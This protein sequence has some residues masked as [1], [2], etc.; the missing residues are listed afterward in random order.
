MILIGLNLRLGDKLNCLLIIVTGLF[1]KGFRIVSLGKKNFIPPSG[2]PIKRIETT[3]FFWVTH[4]DVGRLSRFAVALST[5]SCHFFVIRDSISFWRAYKLMYRQLVQK[6]KECYLH[7]KIN[8]LLKNNE[9]WTG[10]LV[11]SNKS[12]MD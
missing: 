10:N 1:S 3:G 5:H 6:T 12:V 2:H 11:K 7:H 4:G 9:I 8:W